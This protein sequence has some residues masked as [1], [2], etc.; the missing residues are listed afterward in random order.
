MLL[1]RCV[2]LHRNR[3]GLTLLELI[4]ALGIL[5]ALSTIAVRAIDPLADQS[6]YEATQRLLDDLRDATVGSALARQVNGQPIVSGYLADTGSLPTNVSDFLSM[7]AGLIAHQIQSFDSDRDSIND[8]TLASGWNGPYV[9]RGAGQT[10][11]LDGW[12]R[13]PLIGSDGGE[14]ALVSLGSDNDSVLPEDG[15]QAD[16]KATIPASRF[17]SSVTFRLFAIDGNTH[18]RIDPSPSGLQRLGILLYAV[19]ANGGTSGAI[20]EV[21]LNVD[22]SFEASQSAIIHGPAAARGILWSDTNSDGQLDSGES[23]SLRS[24]VHHFTVTGDSNLRIEMELR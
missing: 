12:G 19:N 9:L 15:Y 4:V 21:M 24:F 11:L 5:A 7:P 3:R 22:G 17:S 13:P 18:T 16:L 20:E 6:R 10:E 8:V 1:S 2:R 23:I 14:F